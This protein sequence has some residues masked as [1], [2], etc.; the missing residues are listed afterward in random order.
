MQFLEVSQKLV[1]VLSSFSENANYRRSANHGNH[2][3][4]HGEAFEMMVRAHV[5]VSGF[6][7]GVFFRYETRAEATRFRVNGWVKN[8][9]DGRVEAVFEGEKEAVERII[10][11]CKRG[12][13]GAEV[14]GVEVKWEEW[15]GEYKDFRIVYY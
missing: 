1:R 12:P 15:N 5:W 4:V 9:R 7:Q 2:G 3:R 14:S 13:P 8:L 10:Q 6:V 11:F